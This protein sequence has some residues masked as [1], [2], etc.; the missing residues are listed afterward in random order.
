VDLVVVGVAWPRPSCDVTSFAH[1][2]APGAARGC[3]VGRLRDDVRCERDEIVIATD[4]APPRTYT[5]DARGVFAACDVS[6][7]MH[8]VTL[9]GRRGSTRCIV[10]VREG[11][12]AYASMGPDDAGAIAIA[13]YV[14]RGDAPR[15]I[16]I[17]LALADAAEAPEPGAKLRVALAPTP[18]AG[19]YRASRCSLS[20]IDAA[21]APAQGCAHCGAAQ[22]PD[23]L[24]VAALAVLARRR[25][26][27]R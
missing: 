9:C 23:A 22:G 18:R 15:V 16:S 5:A 21:P 7:G 12:V 14:L 11:E 24:A 10:E 26:R 20:A 4:G 1:P 19:H 2:A 25:R 13:A 6:P 17:E 8:E 27:R 3:V